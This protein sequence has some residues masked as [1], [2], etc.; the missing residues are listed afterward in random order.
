[1]TYP[2]LANGCEDVLTLKCHKL[3]II[4]YQVQ[5]DITPQIVHVKSEIKSK[6]QT[7]FILSFAVVSLES[8][9]RFIH[10]L[11]QDMFHVFQ[12]FSRA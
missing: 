5:E 2:V 6:Y 8:G 10:N 11:Q 1:M 12:I 9:A 7:F 3:F 4:H